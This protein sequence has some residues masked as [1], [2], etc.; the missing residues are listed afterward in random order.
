MGWC[1]IFV[2]H[3]DYTVPV[4]LFFPSKLTDLSGFPT[5]SQKN[6]FFPCTFPFSSDFVSCRYNIN[7]SK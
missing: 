7:N 3:I 4:T 2:F 5:G 1:K 6:R